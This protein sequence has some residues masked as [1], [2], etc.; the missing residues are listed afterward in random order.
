[1]KISF[2]LDGV[3]VEGNHHYVF[4]ILDIIRGLNPE[5]AEIAEMD[6]YSSRALKH[7]PAVFLSKDD[8]AAIITCRKPKAKKATKDYLKKNEIKALIIFADKKGEI[9]WSSPYKKAS[10]KAARLKAKAIRD[11]GS[12]VHFDNNPIMV[13][14]LRKLCPETKII[15]VNE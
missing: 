6:F 5:A 1:V 10:K 3:I 13:K 12:E 11:F 9:D 2:D 8:E 4:R 7:R 14:E 15:L